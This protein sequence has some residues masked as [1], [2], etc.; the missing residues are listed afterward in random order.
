M[1][2]CLVVLSVDVC[3][4]SRSSSNNNDSS[5]GSSSSSSSSGGSSSRSSE[6]RPESAQGLQAGRRRSVRHRLG[7]APA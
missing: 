5:S 3:S 6:D 2:V 4:S 1:Y 7:S